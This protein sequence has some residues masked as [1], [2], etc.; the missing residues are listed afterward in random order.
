MKT[1]GFD[2]QVFIYEV[3]CILR[4]REICGRKHI[5]D[6][7]SGNLKFFSYFQVVFPLIAAFLEMRTMLPWQ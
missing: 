7:V 1:L 3:V 5:C 6:N 4:C 2:R